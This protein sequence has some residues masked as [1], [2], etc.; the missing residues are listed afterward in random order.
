MAT[1]S[2]ASEEKATWSR[3]Q[4][5]PIDVRLFSTEAKVPCHDRTDLF[6]DARSYTKARQWCASCPFR[7]RCSYNAVATRATHGVWGGMVLPGSYPKRL[8]QIYGQLA[9]QFE[10]RRVQELGD[11]P[12]APL[13]SSYEIADEDEGEDRQSGGVA[14]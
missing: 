3:L 12:V 9:E 8:E 6:F 14:A 7:G 10:R 11:I 4:V 1:T 5:D 13:F 2:S